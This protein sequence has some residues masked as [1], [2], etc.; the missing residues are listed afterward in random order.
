[1]AETND[2]WGWSHH[3]WPNATCQ[4][5]R[6]QHG[7]RSF[8]DCASSWFF[9]QSLS[10]VCYSYYIKASFWSGW[11]NINEIPSPRYSWYFHQILDCPKSSCRRWLLRVSESTD[12]GSYNL[13]PTFHETRVR[14]GISQTFDFVWESVCLKGAT[15]WKGGNE[16][17]EMKWNEWNEMKWHEMKWHDMT[18][19]EMKWNEWNEMN[20]MNWNEM[21]WHDMKWNEWNE[22]KWHD[23]TWHEMNVLKWNEWTIYINIASS[24]IP[25]IFQ[26]SPE[27]FKLW[28]W[29]QVMPMATCNPNSQS[30][31]QSYPKA[32][33]RVY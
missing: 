25:S 11:W 29:I 4:N 18:W 28:R 32:L 24:N 21:T 13:R 1:M 27:V 33:L 19:N 30:P 16:M 5:G 23:M 6:N 31:P 9:K 7:G 22:M 17:N 26:K 14:I 12:V 10:V 20:E 3:F 2:A 15:C 8:F